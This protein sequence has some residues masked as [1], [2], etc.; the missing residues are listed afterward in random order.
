GNQQ[1]I[2]LA[3]GS[4]T[5]PATGA[6]GAWNDIQGR[7]YFYANGGTPNRLYRYDPLTNMLTDLAAVAP[8]GTFD[9]TACFPTTLEKEIIQPPDG[10]V[11]GD[12]VEVEFSIYNGQALPQTY[13][14]EDVLESPDL[15]WNP[16]SVTPASPGGGTVTFSDQTLTITDM[17]VDP[18]AATANLPVT[19]TV[20]YTIDPAASRMACYTNQ[21]SITTGGI[22]V[23]S[24]DP[25]TLEPIDPTYFCLSLCDVPAPTSGGNQYHCAEA[26]SIPA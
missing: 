7:V 24:D 21:A 1:I 18:I 10:F 20:S 6:G 3:P 15:S 25:S 9:A 17:V 16:T 26:G 12:V 11:P 5:A 19:F 4:A 14:F 2:N 13:Q 8:Y 22:E 23:L